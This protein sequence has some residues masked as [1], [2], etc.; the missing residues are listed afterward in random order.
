MASYRIME[1][2]FNVQIINTT[3][4]L[5]M[6]KTCNRYSSASCCRLLAKSACPFP[7]KDLNIKG[8]IPWNTTKYLKSTQRTKVLAKLRLIKFKDHTSRDTLSIPEPP[9]LC[10]ALGSSTR[11]L[12]MRLKWWGPTWD[13]TRAL[14]GWN[15]VPLPWLSWLEYQRITT[16]RYNTFIFYRSA[17]TKCR[18]KG[19]NSVIKMSVR[20]ET[21]LN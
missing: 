19:D 16:V 8:R 13:G 7:T 6:D 18:I 2:H 3:C 5:I 20:Y 17:D 9:V 12:V 1:G 11:I 15:H 4:L 21:R 10:R 14:P